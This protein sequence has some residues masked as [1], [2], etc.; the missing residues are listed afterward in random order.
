MHQTF[1][2]DGMVT[3]RQFWKECNGNLV[4]QLDEGN[5]GAVDGHVYYRR[6]L[7]WEGEYSNGL[8]WGQFHW[9]PG[10]FPPLTPVQFSP[11]TV[12]LSN[13]TGHWRM[14]VCPLS[15]FWMSEGDL[16][17]GLEEGRWSYQACDG[18]LY[19]FGDYAGGLKTGEWRTIENQQLIE[20][21]SYK[22]G[23]AEG[24]F[25]LQRDGVRLEG[26]QTGGFVFPAEPVQDLGQYVGTWR[27]YDASGHLLQEND[28]VGGF[29]HFVARS[30]AGTKVSEGDVVSG[31]RDGKWVFYDKFEN[32]ARVVIYKN[33]IPQ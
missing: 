18:T 33:G 10:A 32:V 3:G 22:N 16:K 20:R 4:Y 29:G 31:A 1:T 11:S 19:T 8:P 17:S 2:S 21:T 15:V 26:E 13:G 9:K 27:F 28:I 24:P 6:N 23:V 30:S 14:N 5:G 25:M 7:I 12:T